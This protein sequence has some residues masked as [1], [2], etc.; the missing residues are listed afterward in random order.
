MRVHVRGRTNLWETI[1]VPTE[2]DAI[3]KI[4]ERYP[5]A[6]S[7]SWQTDNDRLLPESQPRG[8]IKLLYENQRALNL[9]SPPIAKIR[10]D[11]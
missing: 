11:S 10:K 6:V 5:A 2:D 3:R 4:K 1:I 8:Q 7:S 9:R